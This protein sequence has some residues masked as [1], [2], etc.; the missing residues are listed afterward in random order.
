MSDYRRLF[1]PGGTF[2]FTVVTHKGRA[3][4]CEPHARH[5]L[6]AAIERVRSERPFEALA[7][8]LLPNHFHCIWK[9]P[10][11]DADF[12]IRMACIKKDFTKS[13][14][15]GGGDEIG[16]SRAR[17]NRRERAVWQRRF[18]EH[19][20]R[21]E[22]DLAR[23]VNYIHYNPV[24]HRM[25]RCPHEWPFSSFHR[26]AEDG[27]YARDWFC[28]CEDDGADPPAFEDIAETVGE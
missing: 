20:M 21:D 6:R 13:W 26:W 4:L 8:V 10:D 1:R 23:H 11:A 12:S 28:N 24:K 19:T 5:C 14:L 25:T 7:F 2:F 22:D 18:W 16:I 3:F 15:A 17:R 9:L 27:Y